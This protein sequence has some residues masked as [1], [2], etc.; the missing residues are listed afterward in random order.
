M[1][2]HDQGEQVYVYTAARQGYV[3]G[4]LFPPSQWKRLRFVSAKSADYI[5]DNFHGN[6][7]KKLLPPEKELTNI[8]VNGVT[9][10]T[11]YEGHDM[12]GLYKKHTE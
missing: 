11:V 12:E 6:G 9:L 4:D 10:L 7:Y 5:L 2:A 1:L 8:Q 3:S